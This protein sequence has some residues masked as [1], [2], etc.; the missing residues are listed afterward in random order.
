MS[1]HHE[2]VRHAL[3]RKGCFVGGAWPI[4][5]AALAALVDLGLPDEMIARYFMIEPRSVVAPACALWCRA[6]CVAVRPA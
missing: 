6:L 1:A 2:G 3:S 5:G 4:S